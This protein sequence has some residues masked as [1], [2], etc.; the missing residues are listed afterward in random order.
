MWIFFTPNIINW[1]RAI[2]PSSSVGAVH[3]AFKSLAIYLDVTN[4]DKSSRK[5]KIIK[6]NKSFNRHTKIVILI[7]TRLHTMRVK[8]SKDCLDKK[9]KEDKKYQQTIGLLTRH[10]VSAIWKMIVDVVNMENN[11]ICYSI[12]ESFGDYIGDIVNQISQKVDT[13]NIIL[14][15]TAFA[16]QPLYARIQKNLSLYN[17]LTNKNIPISK[18]SALYGAQYL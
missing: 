11:I 9:I 18:E 17:I 13:K 12:Y 15:G 1:L 8:E 6:A 7:A 10:L 14:S 4:L 5:Q 2:C 3:I 16:N